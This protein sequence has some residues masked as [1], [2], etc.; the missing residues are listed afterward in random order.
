MGIDLGTTNSA[1]ARVVGRT[2]TILTGPDGRRT[3]PSVVSFTPAVLVGAPAVRAASANAENTFFSVKRLLGRSFADEG[4]QEELSHLPF[5]ARAGAGGGVLL[6]CPA[7]SRG[8]APEAVSALVLRQ[9]ASFAAPQE[10][11]LRAVLAVPARFDDAQRQAT[12]TAAAAAGLDVLR[13]L[14]E[15]T[16]AAL[17]YGFGCPAGGGQAASP[18]EEVREE[19]LVLVFDLGGGTLDV[20]LLDVS[21]GVFQVLAS[22]GDA[23]LGGNDFDAV[24]VSWLREQQQLA[25]GAVADSAQSLLVAAEALKVALSQETQVAVSLAPGG[26][27]AVLTRAELERRCATLL[28]R[29]AQP[30]HR[31]LEDAV[32]SDGRSVA[33]EDLAA[34]LLVGGATRMPAVRALVRE[35]TRQVRPPRCPHLARADPR[36]AGPARRR[37]PRRGRCPGLRRAGGCAGRAD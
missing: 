27:Q 31:V 1:V 29:C 28:A 15:P 36:C 35:V 32:R 37:G 17:A 10:A 26:A 3:T 21:C 13:L 24:V 19:E 18:G 34:V 8:L 4:V 33:P 14:N 5:Q 22:S 2:A 23:R 20:S 7:L 30:L 6:H 12:L 9:L 11:P 16:A 25:G